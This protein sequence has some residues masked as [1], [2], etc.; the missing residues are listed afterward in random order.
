LFELKA[1]AHHKLGNFSEEMKILEKTFLLTEE[2]FGP[3][4]AKTFEVMFKLGLVCS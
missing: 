2:Y 1:E 3:T 4:H